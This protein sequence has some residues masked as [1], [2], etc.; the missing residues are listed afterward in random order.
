MPPQRATRL[1]ISSGERACEWATYSFQGSISVCLFMVWFLERFG[2]AFDRACGQAG[3]DLFGGDEGEDQ[4]WQRDE[5][6]RGHDLSPLHARV[7]DVV[8]DRRG[9]GS[10]DPIWP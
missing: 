6:A 1:A 7:G 10:R 4:R 5:H 2:S 9:Q 3:D 8:G